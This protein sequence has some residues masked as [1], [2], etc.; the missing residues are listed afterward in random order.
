[1]SEITQYYLESRQKYEA[2]L[3][4]LSPTERAKV[5]ANA[6]ALCDKYNKD[7]HSSR[8]TSFSISTIKELAEEKLVADDR[9]KINYSRKSGRTA[10]Y[11]A[12]EKR[13]KK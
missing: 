3:A 9:K 5:E 7:F 8:L 2:N 13:K 10:Y 12:K 1:M 11:K 4:T 6:Q